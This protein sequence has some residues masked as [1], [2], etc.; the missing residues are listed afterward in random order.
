MSKHIGSSLSSLL[1]E[2][3]IRAETDALTLKKMI[4]DRT[5]ELMTVQHVTKSELAR[6]MSTSATSVDRLLDP[7]ND[8]LTLNTIVALQHALGGAQIVSVPKPR[9]S[10]PKSRAA[11]DTARSARARG[12]QNARRRPVG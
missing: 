10:R 2:R 6:R 12:N 4:V 9:G 1:E 7:T 11:A 8:G 5:R 3:G